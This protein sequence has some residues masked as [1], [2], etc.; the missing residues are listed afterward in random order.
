MAIREGSAVWNGLLKD[1]NGT[2][3]TETGTL[4]KNPYSFHSRFEDG[5]GTNPEELIGAAHAGCFSMAL[6]AELGRA[7]Y[8]PTSIETSDKVHLVKGDDGFSIEKITINMEAEISEIDEDTFLEYA[9][10]AKEN[11]PVS[12]ALAGVEFELNATLK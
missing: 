7:G 2:V 3:S 6:S 9:N 5:A 8:T 11:C 1:G 4:N 10:G 12:R